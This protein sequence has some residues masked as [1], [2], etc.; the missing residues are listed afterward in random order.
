MRAW[1]FTILR[2]TYYSSR[3]K[4]NRE[5]ADID[6]QA[7]ADAFAEQAPSMMAAWHL[8]IF[9][10]R[11]RSC[12][13]NSARALMLVG[14]FWVFSY[15]EAAETCGVAVGTVKSRANRG[16]QRLAELLGARGR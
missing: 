16:R 4:L 13:T 6:G 8:P 9:A 14:R 11:S 7:A 3:R 15:E 2:N 10:A 12:P 5:V 1:L